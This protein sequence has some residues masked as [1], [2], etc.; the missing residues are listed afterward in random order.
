M[1]ANDER[2]RKNSLLCHT[3]LT[4]E[5]ARKSS[6]KPAQKNPQLIPSISNLPSCNQQ[7]TKSLKQKM[8]AKNN[9]LK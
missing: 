6:I 5:R 3:L 7:T 8:Q 9:Q 4:R 2:Q 1:N